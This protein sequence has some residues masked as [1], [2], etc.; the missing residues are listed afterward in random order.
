MKQRC[1]AKTIWERRSASARIWSVGFRANAVAA[2]VFNALEL[3]ESRGLSNV[4][5]ANNH[6]NQRAAI[7]PRTRSSVLLRRPGAGASLT[8]LNQ[9]AHAI[10]GGQSARIFPPQACRG[11]NSPEPHRCT[12]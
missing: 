3:K 12:Y 8:G 10:P 2:P 1:I 9:R 4:V 11:N 5:T 6:A 7:P